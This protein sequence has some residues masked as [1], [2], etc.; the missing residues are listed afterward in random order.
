MSLEEYVNKDFYNKKRYAFKKLAATIITE[1]NNLSG[2]VEIRFSKDEFAN[3]MQLV[4][5]GYVTK[6]DEMVSKQYKMYGT[7]YNFKTTTWGLTDK[8]IEIAI[9]NMNRESVEL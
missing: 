5:D 2:K 3:I 8:G 9:K 1:H 4:R 6:H 7:K